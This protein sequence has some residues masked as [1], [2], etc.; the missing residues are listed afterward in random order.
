MAITCGARF[1]PGDDSYSQAGE[2]L[3]RHDPLWR[4]PSLSDTD[5]QYRVVRQMARQ[6][7]SS[8]AEKWAQAGKSGRGQY[9]C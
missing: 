9:L 6:G 1:T 2:S 8:L 7:Q 3:R 4:V 5:L